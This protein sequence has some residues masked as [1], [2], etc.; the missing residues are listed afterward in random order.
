MKT[1]TA[2]P[3]P[4]TEELRAHMGSEYMDARTFL[5]QATKRVKVSDETFHGSN[6]SD[7]GASATVIDATE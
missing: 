1:A 5:L 4:A 3:L 2:K 7:F 6:A